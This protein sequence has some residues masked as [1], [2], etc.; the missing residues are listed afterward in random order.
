[1]ALNDILTYGK[2]QTPAIFQRRVGIRSTVK[3]FK[4]QFLLILRN[5]LSG[6]KYLDDRDC[7]LTIDAYFYRA[8]FR[9]IFDRI[10]HQVR[11]HLAQSLTIG[12][13][14]HRCWWNF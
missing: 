10:I 1:M 9:G 11:H 4:Y 14:K 5:A 12:P 2:T 7:F 6:I 8:L 3:R 13:Q